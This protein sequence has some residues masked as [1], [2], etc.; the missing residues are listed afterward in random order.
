MPEQTK[1][2]WRIRD[3]G[4][5]ETA[6]PRGR[7]R[8]GGSERALEA[9]GPE[10]A[11]LRAL[12]ELGLGRGVGPGDLHVVGR[13]VHVPEIGEHGEVA[14]DGVLAGEVDVRALLA[15]GEG[16][17][18]DAAAAHG[19]AALATEVVPVEARVPGLA[20]HAHAPVAALGV[21]SREVARARPDH[22]LRTAVG[23]DLHPPRPARQEREGLAVVHVETLGAHAGGEIVLRRDLERV[24]EHRVEPV[25]RQEL[26][27]GVEGSRAEEVREVAAERAHGKEADA[28]EIPLEADLRGARAPCLDA[29]VVDRDAVRD[30][31][32]RLE[33]G[34]GDAARVLVE[35]GP[36]D[37]GVPRRARD[38]VLAELVA[39]VDA[40]EPAQVFLLH[41]GA[42]VD[43][44]GAARRVDAR[45]LEV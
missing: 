18:L 8:G 21:V 37:R 31:R 44:R 42:A 5:D 29:G 35:I 36:A 28:L 23:E 19:A 20:A 39:R 34:K 26:R 11:E 9:D 10:G 33:I 25:Q 13:V 45:D 3:D 27:C 41:A 7:N 24:V 30:A 40:G 6:I 22:A 4:S 43:Q 15:P 2:K 38:Q 12:A 1:S 14:A 17:G 32:R 16:A